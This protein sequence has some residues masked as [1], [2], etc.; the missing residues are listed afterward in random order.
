MRNIKF[1]AVVALMVAAMHAG[2]QT[3]HVINFCNTLDK[4]IGADVDAGRLYEHSKLFAAATGYELAYKAGLGED[5]SRENLMASLD[6]LYCEKNDIVLFYYSGH[7]MRSNRDKSPFPQM[8]LKYEGYEE[9]KWVPVHTVVE[10]LAPKGA[11]LVVVLTD[12]CNSVGD[13]VT[14]KGKSPKEKDEGSISATVMSNLR[15]LFLDSRGVVVATS[16]QA[17]QSSL[18]DEKLGGLFSKVLFEYSIYNASVGAIPATWERVLTD[19]QNQIKEAN[20]TQVPY[21]EIRVQSTSASSQTASTTTTA[22]TTPT[23][24]SSDNSFSKELSRLLMRNQ[25][26]EERLNLA[27]EL[28]GK[29]F[30]ANSKV[31]TVGRNGS[32]II[33][34]ES[35]YDW[36]HR[37][38][39]SHTID[40]I[41]IIKETSDN[42]GRRS[43]IRVQEVRQN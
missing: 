19:V 20:F 13:Y 8:C 17:G 18:G 12:C 29:Y 5:C 42:Q 14:M 2:A 41:I 9:D 6:L 10:K 39:A 21:H 7:G 1:I 25:R 27:E 38:A 4:G 32:T 26:R 37:L 28:Y 34:Y 35:A 40:T 3:M 36:L 24:V 31:A 43:F 11:Q 15:K 30:S 16:S 22:T 33:D 23:V